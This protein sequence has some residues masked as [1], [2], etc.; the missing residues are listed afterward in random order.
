MG[1]SFRDG[2]D[3]PLPCLSPEGIE[4]KKSNCLQSW[5][6]DILLRILWSIGSAPQ[7]RICGQMMEGPFSSSLQSNWK[8]C[9]CL[10]AWFFPKLFAFCREALRFSFWNTQ[11]EGPITMLPWIFPFQ[12]LEIEGFGDLAIF[13]PPE[14]LVDTSRQRNVVRG[15]A[16]SITCLAAHYLTSRSKVLLEVPLFWLF[17]NF[18]DWNQ[19]L[20]RF[21]NWSVGVWFCC[22]GVSKCLKG[23]SVVISK[24]LKQGFRWFGQSSNENARCS[25]Q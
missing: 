17:E 3:V 14:L 23:S 18:W 5:T 7:F 2:Q 21:F 24:Y 9:A 11:F 15:L 4:A 19:T 16:P 8:S 22:M 13:G 6:Y 12:T 10:T 1:K 20:Q 25:G